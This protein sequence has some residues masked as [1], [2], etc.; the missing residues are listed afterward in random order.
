MTEKEAT[1]LIKQ[2]KQ[3]KI[4]DEDNHPIKYNTSKAIRDVKITINFN[5]AYVKTATKR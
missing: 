5:D 4:F 2:I 3:L 1:A